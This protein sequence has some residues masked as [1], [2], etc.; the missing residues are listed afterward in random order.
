MEQIRWLGEITHTVIQRNYL[1][2]CK[3]QVIYKWYLG[4]W[5]THLC[6]GWPADPRIGLAVSG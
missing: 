5:P 2:V 6:A 1:V 4:V 3:H